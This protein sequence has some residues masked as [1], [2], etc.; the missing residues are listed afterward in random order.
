[1]AQNFNE[2]SLAV[3]F[4]RGH[5]SKSSLCADTVHTPDMANSQLKTSG[6]CDPAKDR[7]FGPGVQ[8]SQF[9]FTLTFEQ[10]IFGVGISSFYLIC[11]FIRLGQLHRKPIKTLPSPFFAAKLVCA[12]ESKFV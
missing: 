1:M 12:V 4:K 2:E 9:D 10:A 6:P 8:C 3:A 5:V 7:P 11:S